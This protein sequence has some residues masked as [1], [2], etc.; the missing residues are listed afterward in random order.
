M[1]E[2][3]IITLWL[4]PTL[5]ILHFCIFCCITNMDHLYYLI[6][7]EKNMCHPDYPC[8]I[9]ERVF[10]NDTKRHETRIYTSLKDCII[11][12]HSF[13]CKQFPT[14]YP[15]ETGVPTW[16]QVMKFVNSRGYTDHKDCEYLKDLGKWNHLKFDQNRHLLELFMNR[17]G[18][19]F[20]YLD[21][22]D[23][24]HG[25]Q[26]V[27]G[28]TYGGLN[29]LGKS[30]SELARLMNQT[31]SFCSCSRYEHYTNIDLQEHGFIVKKQPVMKAPPTFDF[32]ALYPHI[33]RAYD[34]Q[35]RFMDIPISARPQTPPSQVMPGDMCTTAIMDKGVTQL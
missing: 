14:E 23:Q 16:D 24:V 28:G 4:I 31:C 7:D 33:I 20:R 32:H 27:P 15:S 9:R 25:S 13:I 6:E 26:K 19:F 12:N 22:D 34:S 8:E 5:I 29:L 30:L 10:D 11:Q 3:I 35:D 2:N 1:L 17:K 21:T 18:T